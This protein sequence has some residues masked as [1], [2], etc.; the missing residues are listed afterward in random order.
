MSCPRDSREEERT[1]SDSATVA[2]SVRQGPRRQKL[3]AHGTRRH[4]QDGALAKTGERITC[5]RTFPQRPDPPMHPE[6]GRGG[7]GGLPVPGPPGPTSV[8][9]LPRRERHGGRVLACRVV[10]A[11]Q[12]PTALYYRLH[13]LF[14]SPCADN[15]YPSTDR[16]RSLELCSLRWCKDDDGVTAERRRL[17]LAGRGRSRRGQ[18]SIALIDA[19]MMDY[20]RPK[21][22]FLS[23]SQNNRNHFHGKKK[24]AKYIRTN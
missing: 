12:P 3:A 14:L 8:L 20:V 23:I 2:S 21:N 7:R 11:P 22:K 19:F 10:R 16:V 6:R 1:G 13:L 5:A 18:R 4:G 9:V 24:R 17:P 15:L